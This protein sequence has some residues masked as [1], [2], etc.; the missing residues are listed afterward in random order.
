MPTTTRCR[1]ADCEWCDGRGVIQGYGFF[2]GGDPRDFDPDPECSTEEERE[3]H[4]V[5]CANFKAVLGGVPASHVQNAAGWATLIRF[6]LGVYTIRCPECCDGAVEEPPCKR[7]GTPADEG[8]L[9]ALAEV[10]RG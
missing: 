8:C 5:A 6:G 9:C 7:C 10:P 4:R 1:V 2:P 3:A